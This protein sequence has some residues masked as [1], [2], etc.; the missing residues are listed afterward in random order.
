VIDP[1][2]LHMVLGV[3]TGW[4]HRRERETVAYLIEENRVSFHD[5]AGVFRDG[6]CYKLWLVIGCVRRRGC[7]ARLIR[8]RQSLLTLKAVL[9]RSPQ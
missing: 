4:R 6:P 9:E 3:L 8:D 1:A 5:W 2:V 7:A